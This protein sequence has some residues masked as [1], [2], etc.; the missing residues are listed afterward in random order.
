[1]LVSSVDSNPYKAD[2]SSQSVWSCLPLACFFLPLR[3][4]PSRLLVSSPTKVLPPTT[5]QVSNSIS[6]HRQC[7]NVLQSQPC[8][9]MNPTTRPSSRLVVFRR[10]RYLRSFSPGERGS[11][12]DLPHAVLGLAQEWSRRY[13]RSVH[14]IPISKDPTIDRAPQA[15]PARSSTCPPPRPVSTATPK[16]ISWPST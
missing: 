16:S 10:P 2:D 14:S 9:T 12:H 13:Q 5:T 1:V 15:V 4:P 7:L 3:L 11:V 6:L 8:P